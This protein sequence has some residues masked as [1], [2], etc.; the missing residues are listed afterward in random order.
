MKTK[1]LA[2]LSVVFFFFS[3]IP[4]SGQSPIFSGEWKLNKEKST[5]QNNQLFLSKMTILQ[6]NDSIFTNRVYE[7]GY[8]EAYPFQENLSL[9]GAESKITIYDMPRK[10]KASLTENN[11][12]IAFESITTFYGNGGA[13]DLK[14]K[15]TWSVENE[16]KMLKIDYSTSYSGGTSD[17]TLYFDKVK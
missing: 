15:E 17:G 8:G 11:K 6:K 4:A 12:S 1:I 9:N 13:D 7:N 5:G 10:A 3:F 2:V 16:G 14:T